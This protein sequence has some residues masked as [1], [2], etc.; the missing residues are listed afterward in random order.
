M[1]VEPRVTISDTIGDPIHYYTNAIQGI[2][3]DKL[4]IANESTLT[5]SDSRSEL[6]VTSKMFDF[7]GEKS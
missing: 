4:G 1:T 3:L 2:V 5:C 6:L 7:D